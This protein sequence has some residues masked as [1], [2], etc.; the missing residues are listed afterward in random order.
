VS[1]LRG[2]FAHAAVFAGAGAVAVSTYVIIANSLIR[3]RL[4]TWTP[5]KADASAIR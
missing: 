5:D 1:G 2:E 3:T 4:T